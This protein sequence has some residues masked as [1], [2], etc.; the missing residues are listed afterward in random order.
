VA[1]TT[2]IVSITGIAVSGVLG[3]WINGWV[4]RRANRQQFEQDR[5]GQDRDDLAHLVDE[6]AEL[7]AAGVTNLRLT[8]EATQSGRKV[9]PEVEEWTARVF[10]L[11]QRLR[12]RVPADDPIVSGYSRVRERLLVVARLAKDPTAASGAIAAFES[13]RDR[14]LDAARGR[15]DAPVTGTMKPRRLPIRRGDHAA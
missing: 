7:L 11:E 4:V 6:A 9:P 14:F 5:A 12:L 1:D 10:P 2:L 13:E 3:P 8:A 15:L